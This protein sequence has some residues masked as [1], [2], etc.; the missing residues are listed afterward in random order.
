MALTKEETQKLETFKNLKL[1][2]SQTGII[3]GRELSDSEWSMLTKDCKLVFAA[4][5]KEAASRA[6]QKQEIHD[7]KMHR[8]NK[9]SHEQDTYF[10]KSLFKHYTEDYKISKINTYYNEMFKTERS[11]WKIVGSIDIFR[12]NN[13]IAELVHKMTE[14]QP[15]NVK[16]QVCLSNVK[17]DKVVQ[18]KLLDKQEIVNKLAEWV[19]LFIDY[20]DMDIEDITFKLM[21]IEVP[22]GAGKRVNAIVDAQSKRSIIRVVNYDSK[23]L[24]RSIV[25]ALA[26]KH[27]EKLQETLIGKL[28]ESEIKEI[29]NRRQN[30][31]QINEGF[32]ADNEVKDIGMGRKLQTLLANILH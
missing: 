3:I 16:L 8:L 23:C 10:I 25:V 12:M 5:A 19:N 22:A 24:A 20:H 13:V 14:N 4:I 18:T 30:K 1:D 2:R 9:A 28:V 15:K 29:N 7:K 26:K 17:N 6:R 11:D 21:A 27:K 31:T 32:I